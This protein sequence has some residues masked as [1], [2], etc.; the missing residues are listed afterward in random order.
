VQLCGFTDVHHLRVHTHQQATVQA[1]AATTLACGQEIFG[2]GQN[3]DKPS[4][5]SQIIF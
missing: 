4:N 2:L 3:L 5:S 1:A